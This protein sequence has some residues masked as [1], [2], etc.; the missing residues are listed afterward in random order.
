MV[1]SGKK[2]VFF[3]TRKCDNKT[4]YIT[5]PSWECGWYWS[6]GY[7]GNSNEHYHLKGYSN[8]RNISMYDALLNDYDLNENIKI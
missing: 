1:I 2:N 3:G 4:I 7:L 6:F 8:G 5:K